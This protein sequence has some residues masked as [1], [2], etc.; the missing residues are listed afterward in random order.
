MGKE[1]GAGF[2]N[3]VSADRGEHDEPYNYLKS[4]ELESGGAGGDDN[5]P[6]VNA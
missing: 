3:P 1:I 6:R 2:R 5:G 4:G